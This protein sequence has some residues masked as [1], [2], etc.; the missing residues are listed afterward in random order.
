MAKGCEPW[1]GGAVG[2]LEAT[3]GRTFTDKPSIRYQ[4]LHRTASAV[5]AAQQFGARLA[6]MVVHSFSPSH[7][8]H[9]DYQAFA[10][11]FG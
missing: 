11:E 8:W 7:Q 2:F 6:V 4:L 3:L 10:R 9:D 5:I 1:Q